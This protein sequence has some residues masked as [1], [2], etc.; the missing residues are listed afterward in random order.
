MLLSW[1]QPME[2]QTQYTREMEKCKEKAAWHRF[3]SV[4]NRIFVRLA[5]IDKTAMV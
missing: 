5:C 2:I 4:E 3:L 1:L